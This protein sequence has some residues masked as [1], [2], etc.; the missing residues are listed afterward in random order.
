MI[1]Q[2]IMQNIQNSV[3]VGANGTQSNTMPNVG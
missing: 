3:Q 1:T 2:N